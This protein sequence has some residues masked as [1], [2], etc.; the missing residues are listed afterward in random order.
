MNWKNLLGTVSE[1]VN[2]QLRLRHDYLVAENRILH[3]QIDG[4]VQ[5]TDNERKE[6]AEMGAKLGKPALAEIATV[7]HADTLLAWHRKFAYQTVT[8]ATPPK[9][10]GRPRVDPEIEE[11]V[12]R[13]ARENRS[14]G[15]D[16]I[17]G[18]LKHLG[19]TISDQTVGNILKRHSI[20]PAPERKKTV[21]W[22]EFTRSHWDVF[23]ATG[24]FNSEVW[25]GFRLIVSCWLSFIDSSRHSIQSMRGT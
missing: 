9:S 13:M 14:W 21:T 18:S 19:Y 25:S 7:A 22:G 6:L 5:L 20:P 15:Y 11:W 17:Q 23:L 3:H 24:F 8:S 2:D 4:R 16:R 12:I 1:S 10:V